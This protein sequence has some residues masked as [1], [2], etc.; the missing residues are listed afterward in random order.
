MDDFQ[1]T[2]HTQNQANYHVITQLDVAT[3]YDLLIKT[4]R[5][6]VKHAGVERLGH[7]VVLK[8]THAS[9]VKG[10]VI[11]NFE[12][13]CERCKSRQLGKYNFCFDSFCVARHPICKTF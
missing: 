13:L 1:G 5:H 10:V 3:S 7:A 4:C 11:R 8:C 9:I 2:R 6:V 12:A